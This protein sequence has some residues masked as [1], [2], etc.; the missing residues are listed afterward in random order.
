M[1][2]KI[3]DDKLVKIFWS[4]GG[5]LDDSHFTPPDISSGKVSFVSDKGYRYRVKIID[6]EDELNSDNEEDESEDNVC[7]QCGGYKYYYDDY[8]DDCQEETEDYE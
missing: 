6:Y 4:N 5:W 1:K 8:C 2:V 7:P 3:E